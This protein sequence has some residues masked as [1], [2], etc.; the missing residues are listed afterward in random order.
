MNRVID[1]GAGR[2][3][4]GGDFDLRS[5]AGMGSGLEARSDDARNFGDVARLVIGRARQFVDFGTADGPTW[6]PA[7]QRKDLTVGEKHLSRP[8]QLDL[9]KLDGDLTADLGDL[10]RSRK[11]AQIFGT[12]IIGNA[13]QVALKVGQETNEVVGCHDSGTQT[14]GLPA[15]IIAEQ[16]GIERPDD[17]GFQH[18]ADGL[19]SDRLAAGPL[20]LAGGVAHD[21]LAALHSSDVAVDGLEDA[22]GDLAWLFIR[23]HELQCCEGLRGPLRPGPHTNGKERSCWPTRDP[24]Q[25]PATGTISSAPSAELGSRACSR[26]HPAPDAL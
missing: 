26:H 17:T 25:S 3:A 14:D 24:E 12:E 5:G 4:G 13:Q 22:L 20:D 9:L 23:H 10:A 21:L 6:N 11:L 7:A 15:R 19:S 1:E 16:I 18:D 2:S 8:S